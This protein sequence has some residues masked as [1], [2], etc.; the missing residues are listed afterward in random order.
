M[1]ERPEL[2]VCECGHFRFFH[3]EDR[4]CDGLKKATGWLQGSIS[5]Y[6]IPCECTQFEERDDG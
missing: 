2:E 4:Y 3:F 1:A 6:G 5:P